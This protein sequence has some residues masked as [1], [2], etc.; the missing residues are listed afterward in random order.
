MLSMEFNARI[1]FRYNINLNMMV[2]TWLKGFLLLWPSGYNSM[3]RNG[4]ALEWVGPANFRRGLTGE[5]WFGAVVLVRGGR[6][7]VAASQLVKT[8]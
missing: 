5:K 3:M 7:T 8:E 1:C 6:P 4:A 2:C